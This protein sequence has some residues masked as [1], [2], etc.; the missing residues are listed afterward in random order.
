VGVGKMEG[1]KLWERAGIKLKGILGL[2][3][4]IAVRG[5]GAL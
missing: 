2:A 3:A 5:I 1:I 4:Y